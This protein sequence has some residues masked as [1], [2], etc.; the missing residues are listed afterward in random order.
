MGAIVAV[1]VMAAM[2]AVGASGSGGVVS[3]EP[4]PAE[5][6]WPS[7]EPWVDESAAPLT[8]APTGTPAA[9]PSDLS[10]PRPSATPRSS[11]RL[12]FPVPQATH[13]RL[14]DDVRPALGSARDDEEQL[15]GDGCLAFERVVVPPDCVYGFRDATFTIALVGDSHAAHW[16]P[17]LERVAKHERWRIV[18]FV[19][20]ACPFIDMRVGNVALKREYRECADFNEATI[21]RLGRLRPDLTI[22][23]MS[24]IAIHPV[25]SADDTVAA[26]GAAIGRMVA[27]IPGRTALLVDTPYAGI[28]V[29]GCLS[30]HPSDVD[31]CA[32]AHRTAFLDHLGAIERVAATASGAAVIDLTARICVEDPCPVV[33]DGMIVFR[34]IGHLTATYSRS[35]APALDAEIRRVIHAGDTS[36]VGPG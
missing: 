36:G 21:D 8:P 15:R 4:P 25:V 33:V 14:P 2:P 18:T 32:I 9:T 22:V 29:P 3:A 34:D 17:A 7:D 16:F 24:R 19:K 35:L 23:S 26:K 30:A 5:D 27:R 31:A 28:D 6:R 20:V 10:T 1:V 12:T 13:G 11:G